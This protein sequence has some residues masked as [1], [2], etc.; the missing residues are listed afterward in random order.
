MV[1]LH[2][3]KQLHKR[4]GVRK[5]GTEFEARFQ[6]AEMWRDT[7]RPQVVQI[8]VSSHGRYDEGLYTVSADS[9]RPSIFERLEMRFPELVPLDDAIALAEK[10]KKSFRPK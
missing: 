1:V 9:F 8:P 2:V 5:D 7:R 4:K 10:A 3:F 6:E